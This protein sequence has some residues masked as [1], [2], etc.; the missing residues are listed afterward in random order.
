LTA[1]PGKTSK[2]NNIT[3]NEIASNE[4]ASNGIASNEVV[5][6]EIAILGALCLFLS[7]VE[8]MIP[9]PFPFMRIG[10]ANLPLMLACTIF[11]LRAYLILV[12]VKVFGQALIT[13]T[14]FSYV[15]V[16]SFTGSFLSAVLMFGLYH[17]LSQ[18]HVSF[19]G[20]GTA[21]ALVSNL[22]QICLAHVFIF[23]GN[24]LYIAP[25]FLAA[26]LITGVSLGVFC[27]IFIKNSNWYRNRL[28]KTPINNEIHETAFLDKKPLTF[29]PATKFYNNY[30]GSKALF[31]AGFLV[32]PSLVFN[33]ST[34]YR[35]AQFLF[36]LLLACLFGRKVNIII[37]FLVTFFIIVFNLIIPYGR[38][39]LYIGGFTI[40][41]GALEAGIHRAVTLQALFMLSKVTIR[42]DL[43]LPGRFGELLGESLRMFSRLISRGKTK[44]KKNP[45]ETIDNLLFDL[46]QS[47]PA[48]AVNQGIRT[49]PAGY[50]VLIIIVLIS[51]L[52][53]IIII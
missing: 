2:K 41:K 18:R 1:S 5:S 40:T 17:A 53:W 31:I 37:T 25:P 23:G 3:N 28:D 10:L 6:N 11:P 21:G 29:F 12:C 42:Q 43:A 8:Y 44:L 13:G 15:F 19:I 35:C 51:W 36:F 26:G 45:I 46:A 52:P 48:A 47:K 9:K 34:E 38:V 50:F 33:S 22:S 16:F 49:K 32:I 7:A 30:F 27:E 14:L 20:I 4:V 24:V 39:L